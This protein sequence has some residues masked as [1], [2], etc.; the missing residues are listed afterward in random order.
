M[1]GHLGMINVCD[2]DC[3][4]ANGCQRGGFQC[5]DCGKWYCGYE[6]EEYLGGGA[7]ADL[8]DSG[9]E[10]CESVVRM[11]EQLLPGSA[12]LATDQTPQEK[13][14]FGRRRGRHAGKRRG[15]SS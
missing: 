15:K 7:A 10:F 3:A 11:V 2:L 14:R 12:L 13:G 5:E 9:N 1:S 4:V 6:V 8:L